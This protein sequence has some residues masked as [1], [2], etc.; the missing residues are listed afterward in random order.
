M[1][2]EFGSGHIF[3]T[4]IN[5]SVIAII[6][7]GGAFKFIFI[8]RESISQVKVQSGIFAKQPGK[9]TCKGTI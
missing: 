1:V 3:R 4:G 6:P 9:P 2:G 8:I 7:E 5:T